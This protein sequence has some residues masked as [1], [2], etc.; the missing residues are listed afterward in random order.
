MDIHDNRYILEEKLKEI[1]GSVAQAKEL[2]RLDDEYTAIVEELEPSKYTVKIRGISPERSIALEE[3][4]IEHFPIEYTEEKNAITGATVKT[5]IES[6]DR[7]AYLTNLI[8]QAH[9]VSITRNIDGAVDTDFA[10]VAKVKTTMQRLPQLARERVDAAIINS[11]IT[12]DFYRALVDPV[13]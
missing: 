2:Q 4:A 9:L 12:A 7:D 11:T 1:K 8:R 10:D 3:D 6:E 13:F 5:E